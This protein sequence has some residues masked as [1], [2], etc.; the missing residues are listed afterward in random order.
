MTAILPIETAV[1][2]LVPDLI[3]DLPHTPFN[4]MTLESKQLLIV[5]IMHA[6]ILAGGAAM[7]ADDRCAF[8]P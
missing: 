8:G 1:Y 4:N 5:P 3:R 2:G 7:P 6:V